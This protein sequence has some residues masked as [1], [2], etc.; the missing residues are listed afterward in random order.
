MKHIRWSAIASHLPGRTDNEIKNF[1]NTHLKKKLIQMGMDPM[2]HR[3]RTDFFNTFQQLIAFAK[4]RELIQSR[5]WD[6]H[7]ARLQDAVNQTAR[8]QY[9]QQLQHLATAAAITSTSET[10]SLSNITSTDLETNCMLGS[11][12]TSVVPSFPSLPSCQDI[13]VQ[14]Y[15]NPVPE[16]EMPCSFDEPVSNGTNQSPLLSGFSIGE[17]SPESSFMSPCSPLPPLIDAS[18]GN[19]GGATTSTSSSG[20]NVNLSESWPEMLFDFPFVN[21][22]A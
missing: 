20:G 16:I 18:I 8:L 1:W 6:E 10:T 21:D 12:M 2:T 9:F 22:F 11:Q 14:K 13:D 7:A 15:V 17:Y 19:L 4:L 3:P 5:P